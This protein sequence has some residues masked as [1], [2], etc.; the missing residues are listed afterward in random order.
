MSQVF[1]PSRGLGACTR[2][3]R[4]TIEILLEQQCLP[5]LSLRKLR[6]RERGIE[7]RREPS[8]GEE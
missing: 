4:R 2:R 7:R 3:S 5:A 8:Q 1:M 6:Q